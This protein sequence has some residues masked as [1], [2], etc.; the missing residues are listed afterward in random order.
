MN[1]LLPAMVLAPVLAAVLAVTGCAAA[2]AALPA[3]TKTAPPL[4]GE[5]LTGTHRQLEDLRGEVV[6]VTIWSSWCAPCRNEVP[7]IQSAYERYRGQGFAVLG[8]NFRDVSDAARTFVAESG[9]SYPSIEDPE[10]RAAVEWG[11]A[12]IPQSFL[13]DRGGMIAA[14]QVGEVTSEWLQQNVTPLLGK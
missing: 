6:L 8:I 5:D 14:R 7:A 3:P 1:R 10:G 2:D 11:V 9:A 4:A 13:V 12:A